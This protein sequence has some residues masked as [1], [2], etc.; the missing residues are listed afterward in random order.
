MQ[1]DFYICKSNVWHWSERGANE[2][3]FKVINDVL[4][5]KYDTEEFSVRE[6]CK[7]ELQPIQKAILKARQARFEYGVTPEVIK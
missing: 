2:S 1:D 7:E 5:E 3:I 4:G 6:A